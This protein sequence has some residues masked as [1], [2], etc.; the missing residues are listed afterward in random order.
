VQNP[1]EGVCNMP[2]Q[3]ITALETITQIHRQK[4]EKPRCA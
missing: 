4:K 1:G 3:G 2:D